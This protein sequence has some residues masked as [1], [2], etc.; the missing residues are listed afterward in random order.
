MD[1]RDYTTEGIAEGLQNTEADS[2]AYH[3]NSKYPEL[4]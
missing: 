1:K 4:L 2:L 3:L